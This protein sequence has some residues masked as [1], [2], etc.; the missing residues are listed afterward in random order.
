[1]PQMLATLRRTIASMKRMRDFMV[2]T[3]SNRW[4]ASRPTQEEGA[5]GSTLMGQYFD[6][7][8]ND[9]SFY[10]PAGV[11]KNPDFERG[12]KMFVSPDARPSG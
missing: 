5:E 11:F 1:M 8:K 6:E 3:H 10:L 2:A 9:D 7:A 12:L 4:P